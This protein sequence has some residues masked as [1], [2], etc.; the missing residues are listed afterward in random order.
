MIFI[1]LKCGRSIYISDFHYSRTYGGL[2]EGRPN[3]EYNNIIIARALSRMEKIWGKRKT[4]LIPPKIDSTD[5]KHPT[6]PTT[7]LTAWITCNQP[8]DANYMGSSLILVWYIDDK[9]FELSSIRDITSVALNAITWNDLAE[10][11]DW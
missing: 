2:L 4:H 5:P 8:V 9:V 1:N 6:L 3:E 10:D 11:F 7:E